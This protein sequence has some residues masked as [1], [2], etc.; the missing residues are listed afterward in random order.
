MHGRVG[1][2][3]LLLVD[4]IRNSIVNGIDDSVRGQFDRTKVVNFNN[5]LKAVFF[6]N[7][8][9][10]RKKTTKCQYRK[11]VHKTFC[12]KKAARKILMKL[13]PVWIGNIFP[14]VDIVVVA[15]NNLALRFEVSPFGV[16]Q[17]RSIR[18]SFRF[19]LVKIH[20]VSIL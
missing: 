2:Q 3:N 13:R 12:T 6:D 5:I 20:L 14:Q 16:S 7:F 8:V 17:L 18:R 15:V 4:P 19:N 9:L 1:A 10:P 11:A